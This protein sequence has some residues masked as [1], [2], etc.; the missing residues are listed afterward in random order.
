MKND[1]VKSLKLCKVSY[2]MSTYRFILYK[3]QSFGKVNTDIRKG[4]QHIFI[5]PNLILLYFSD[6]TTTK[7]KQNTGKF[8]FSSYSPVIGT[9]S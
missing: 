5:L 7:T 4:K 8:V 6:S 9:T 2:I 1:S 3:K